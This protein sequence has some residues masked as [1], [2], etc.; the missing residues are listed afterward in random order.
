MQDKPLRFHVEL[1][2][3]GQDGGERLG[4]AP[5]FSVPLAASERRSLPPGDARRDI[6]NRCSALRPAWI[7]YG[8]VPFTSRDQRE[9][10]RR[11]YGND[12]RGQKQKKHHAD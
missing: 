2:K 11:S 7:R 8:S 10:F 9:C 1:G 12:R 3:V 4:V 6:E 5:A